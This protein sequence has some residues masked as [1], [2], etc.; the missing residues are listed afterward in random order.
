M[1]NNGNKSSITKN[2][3]N[4]SSIIIDIL[5]PYVSIPAGGSLNV[6]R[7]TYLI[8]VNGVD[9]GCLNLKRRD[10]CYSLKVYVV[11][12]AADGMSMWPLG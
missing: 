5:E 6:T 12:V 11:A 3:G 1:I 10:H 2:N 8:H 7:E 9:P 4:K